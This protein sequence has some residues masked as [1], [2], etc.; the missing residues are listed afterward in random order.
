MNIFCLSRLYVTVV[1]VVDSRWSG[2][3][4]VGGRDQRLAASDSGGEVCLSLAAARYPYLAVWQSR[5]SPSPDSVCRLPFQ[6]S[7]SPVSAFSATMCLSIIAINDWVY[8]II[9]V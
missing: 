4:C 8:V 1:N 7:V 5:L 2:R 6:H 9:M 3:V